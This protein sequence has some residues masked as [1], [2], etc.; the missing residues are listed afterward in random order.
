MQKWG[1]LI[2]AMVTPFNSDGS[3]DYGKAGA[4]AG[5]I[6]ENGSDA[7]V[8][9]GTTG[10]SA[11]L[12]TNEKKKLFKTVKYC[13]GNKGAVIANTGTNFTSESV[14]LSAEAAEA[15]VD[16]LLL[17]TPY[18]NKPPQEGLYRHFKKIAF[19]TSLP[20]MLYNVPGRTSC[21]LL[22]ETVARLAE[23]PNIKAIKEASG[24]LGQV[25]GLLRSVPGDFKVYSGDDALTQP[26][27]SMG[28]A[29]VVS[30]A[31][32]IAG[33]ALKKMLRLCELGEYAKA[34]EMSLKLLPLFEMQFAAT[35]PI[36]IKEMLEQLGVFVGG[37]RLP[38]IEADSGLKEKI[39]RCL[40]HYKGE[41]LIDDLTALA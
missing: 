30:V 19:S 21:N 12:Y 15:G 32:N 36:P 41:G 40:E 24:N 5:A 27:M 38:L 20:V 6:I 18:Y 34:G 11:A 22:P 4:L 13:V 8:V 29:G 7:V 9:A 23:I 25:A 26:M 10:E 33:G 14:R 17:V 31:G 35:N 1:K 3:I 39:G 28:A 2:T 37:C 16:G